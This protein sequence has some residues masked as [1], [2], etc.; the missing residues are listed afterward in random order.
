MLTSHTERNTCLCV[1]IATYLLEN[2]RL[3]EEIMFKTFKIYLKNSHF[4]VSKFDKIWEKQTLGF[5]HLPLVMLFKWLVRDLQGATQVP[6]CPCNTQALQEL[7]MK[8]GGSR[9]H[10]VTQPDQNTA[11]RKRQIV[12]PALCFP[13]PS[14]PSPAAAAAADPSVEAQEVKVD[15]KQETASPKGKS[16]QGQASGRVAL[17]QLLLPALPR[18][19]CWMV[20]LDVSGA[21]QGA[22]QMLC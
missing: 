14:E 15:G 1:G 11:C 22:S 17:C 2:G 3:T 12:V 21:V 19:I 6:P 20:L 13:S 4:K 16:L 18:G 8:S 9:G 5:P 7:D 10:T